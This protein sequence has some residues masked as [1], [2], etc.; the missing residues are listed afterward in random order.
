MLEKQRSFII[1][2]ESIQSPNT[3]IT[4][5]YLLAKFLELSCNNYS[6]AEPQK[7]HLC[8]GNG[9]PLS[10]RKLESFKQFGHFLLL[11]SFRGKIDVPILLDNNGM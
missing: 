9:I 11:A 2:E 7:E 10:V 5:L 6:N 4:Y 8:D 3:K 1:F